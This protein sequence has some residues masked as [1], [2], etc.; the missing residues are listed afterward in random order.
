MLQCGRS[1][2]QQNELV[3]ARFSAQGFT[4]QLSHDEDDDDDDDA[5]ARSPH[6][7]NG[8]RAQAGCNKVPMS[9]EC[10]EAAKQSENKKQK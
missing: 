7:R 2:S 4:D 9:T 1:I 5:D 10:S 8:K 3:G 6:R